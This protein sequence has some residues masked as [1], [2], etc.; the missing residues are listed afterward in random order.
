MELAES[1]PCSAKATLPV[2]TTAPSNDVPHL[3]VLL[4]IYE[5]CSV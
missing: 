3:G 5:L 4:R 2:S 1:I